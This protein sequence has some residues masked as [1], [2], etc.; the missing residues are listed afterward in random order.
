MML[1]VICT[2]QQSNS[3]MLGCTSGM[4]KKVGNGL[5]NLDATPYQ[6][7]GVRPKHGKGLC[8]IL[9]HVLATRLERRKVLLQVQGLA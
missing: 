9:F 1:S 3:G 4:Q 2:Q 5:T 7:S 6:S 8:A